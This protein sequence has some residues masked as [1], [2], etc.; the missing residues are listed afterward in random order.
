MKGSEEK[1]NKVLIYL[2]CF[3]LIFLLSGC[4]RVELANK[5]IIAGVGIDKTDDNKV[6][7]TMG[8]INT[9]SNPE[10]QAIGVNVYSFEGETIYDAIRNSIVELGKQPIWPYIKIIVIG[11]SVSKDDISPYLDFF[12]R[13]NEVQPNPYIVFSEVEAEKI[14]QAK[15]DFS[16]IPAAIIEEQLNQQMLVSHVPMIKLHQFTEMMLTPDR[17]GF[18]AIILNKKKGSKEIPKVKNTAVIKDAKWIGTLNSS[19]TRGLLWVRKEVRGGILVIPATKGEG[20]IGLEIMEGEKVAIVPKIKG[21]YL[22]RININVESTVN[23][24]EMLTQTDLGT[25]ET[26]KIQNQAEKQIKEEIASAIEQAKEL[27]VDIFGIGEVIHRKN[28]RYWQKNKQN[29]NDT[30]SSVPIHINVKVE[31]KNI[32]LFNS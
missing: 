5:L 32:G 3:L 29:W 26:T 25:K 19:E 20:K 1:N 15:V 18:A 30:F 9:T 2:S 4:S 6:R 24:G 11:P 21:D 23:I 28:P 22:R 27:E 17:I 8:L 14:V 7:F 16:K 10:R 13:N 31:I 12:N